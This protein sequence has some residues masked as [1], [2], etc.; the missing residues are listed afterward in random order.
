[1]EALSSDFA[2]TYQDKNGEY[3]IYGGFTAVPGSLEI[4]ESTPANLIF[5][6]YKAQEI[7]NGFGNFPTS[8]TA[9][10]ILENEGVYSIGRIKN[11]RFESF[12][13][14]FLNWLKEAIVT[15]YNNAVKNKNEKGKDDLFT[16]DF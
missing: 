5:I 11:Q 13:T 3:L 2:A 12:S 10:L 6:Q 7:I 9:V 4:N 16:Q 15:V 8:R 1:M 14:D